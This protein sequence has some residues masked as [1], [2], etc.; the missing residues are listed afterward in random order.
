MLKTRLIPSLLLKNGRCVKGRNFTNFRDTGNPL[1][2]ARVYDAQGA[3]ELIFLDITASSE[4]R[5]ILFG[6]V[7]KTASNCF[8]PLTVGGGIRNVNDIRKCL[9]A[10]A[11]KTSINTAAVENPNFITE[12]AKIFG[13]QCMVISIDVRGDGKKEKYEVYTHAGSEA[14]GLNP[15]EWA[16]KA[17]KLGAGEILITSIDREGTMTGYDLNLVRSIVDSVKIPVIAQGGVGTLQH[18]VEGVTIGHASAVSA[19][20]IFH[21]TDQSVIKA[22]AYMKEAGLNVRQG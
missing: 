17:E 15:V 21:F 1:T 10:G 11:D 4:N 20:S 12:G 6:L 8:M 5:N 14:T 13:D 16:K 2:A 18:L 7:E 19:A 3:D 9:Q 22:R